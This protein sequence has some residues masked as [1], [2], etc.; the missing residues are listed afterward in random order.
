VLIVK[1][2]LVAVSGASAWA[3]A[4][5]TSKRG[6]AI[7]GALTASSALAVLVLGVVVAG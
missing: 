2:V 4:H 7:G 1:L 5:A 6:L 3:H